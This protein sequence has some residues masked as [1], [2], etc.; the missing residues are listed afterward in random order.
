MNLL[1]DP[2]AEFEKEVLPNGLSVYTAHWP[3]R[4]WEAMGFLIHSGA[5]Q[6]P[7]GLEGLAHF[8]EHL[9][10]DNAKISR[11]ELT[12]FFENCGGRTNYGCTSH[13]DTSYKFFV[14]AEKELLSSA[15]SHF[16]DALLSARFKKAIERERQIIINEFHQRYP[17]KV[18]IDMLTRKNKAIFSG[19]WL[20]RI[21]RPFGNLE[22][23]ARI[24]EH[25]LQLF[26][27]AHYAPRN[28]SVVAVGG[29]TAK[30]IAELL[31]ESHFG[32]E[33]TGERT[34]LPTPVSSMAIPSENRHVIEMSK[35]ITSE[36]KV[37]Y[38]QSYAAIPGSI[39]TGTLRLLCDMFD[40]VLFDEIREQ[41]AWTY[42]VDCSFGDY[43]YFYELNIDCRKFDV[44]AINDIENLI[45][46]CI[47]S[48]NDREDLLEKVKR[49]FIKRQSLV[50]INGRNLC[51][52][53]LGDIATSHR[54]ITL[55]EWLGSIEQVTMSDIREAL[56][57]IRPEHRWTCIAK[58]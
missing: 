7:V 9:T 56:K 32:A 4:P 17:V 35:H 52:N 20:E 37:A 48:M 28:M 24:S 26:Y 11:R 38:Y 34:P 5:E 44:M 1:W 8:V 30:E 47:A 36:M 55:R 50:D 16:G 23:I 39:N 27:D 57:W 43:R 46:I 41:R 51:N 13:Y 15:L 18:D 22:S 40:E 25:D 10:F 29:L 31:A 19:Y 6:D 21:V 53:A 45:E 14:P 12:D 58:P 2:Y 3:N 49:A 54:I 33:K 42:H